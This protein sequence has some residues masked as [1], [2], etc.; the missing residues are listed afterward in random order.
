MPSENSTDT[1]RSVAAAIATDVH[2]WVPALILAA[3][4]LLLTLIR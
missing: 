1:A 3:G 4:L 2:F